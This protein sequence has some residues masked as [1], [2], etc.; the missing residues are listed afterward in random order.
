[1]R[2]ARLLVLFS[3]LCGYCAGQSAAPPKVADL[4]TNDGTKLK[5]TYFAAGNPGPGVLLLHQCNGQRR[6][7]DPLAAALAMHG[8]NVLTVDYR[9]FGDSSGPRYDSMKPDEQNKIQAE[10]WPGDID[11]AYEYLLAQTGVQRDKIAAGG[12]SCGVLNAT[13]LARRHPEV[14]ALMLLSGPTNRQGRMLLDKG[15]TPLFTAAA[16]DDVFGN[17]V[18]TMQWY[19]SVSPNPASRFEHYATGGHG[20]E[21]FA[22]HPELPRMI[23]QWFRAVL[24]GSG[25][26]P[27]TN[28]EKL[29]AQQI[30]MMELMDQPG[31]AAKAMKVLTEARQR[32]PN[33]VI[34]PEFLTNLLGYEHMLA[35][36]AKNAVE[37][38]KLNV[39]AYPNSPNAYDS[40]G[41]AYIAD[42]QKEQ[43]IASAKKCLALL[44]SDTVDN[45]Q[46]K[47]A[48]RE[49]A[50]LKLTQAK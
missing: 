32:N 14:K 22:L 28:G 29:P 43:G 34:L 8:I 17:Q 40:L 38:M 41:D 37:I 45:E 42:G 25:D 11:K 19:F 49:N 47:K 9:G 36:D 48:I 24:K 35:G 30:K 15:N 10:V 26:L 18:A 31:G 6:G 7:W 39:A 23:A 44:E 46:R 5:A 27:A 4:T 20:A 16:D 12:A 3:F 33:A 13:E 2:F 50:E 1:M 21:M